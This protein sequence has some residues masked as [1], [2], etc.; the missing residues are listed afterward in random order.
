MNAKLSTAPQP[1]LEAKTEEILEKLH[2]KVAIGWVRNDGKP[3]ALP[4]H[5]TGDECVKE[6]THAIKEL[7]IEAKVEE[8]NWLRKNWADYMLPEDEGMFDARIEA[9]NKIGEKKDGTSI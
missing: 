9:L 5:A 1:N 3:H 4:T 6:A 8:V 2:E 7:L